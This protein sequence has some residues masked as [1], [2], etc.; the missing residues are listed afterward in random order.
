MEYRL[1]DNNSTVNF[2]MRTGKDL[3][4]SAMTTASAVNICANGKITGDTVNPGYPIVVDNTYYFEGE[5][6]VKKETKMFDKRGKK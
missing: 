5:I 1:K 4:K 2:L 3:V 6:I